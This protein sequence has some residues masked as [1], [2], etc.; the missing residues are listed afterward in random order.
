MLQHFLLDGIIWDR[1]RRYRYGCR[2]S[3]LADSWCGCSC[4]HPSKVGALLIHEPDHM[5]QGW[6]IPQLAV[7]VSRNAVDLANGRKHLRLFDGVDAKVSFEIEIQIQ[8]FF[9]I[10]SLLDHQRENAFL[11]G[12][13]IDNLGIRRSGSRFL[14]DHS[15]F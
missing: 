3:W 13:A 15:G 10:T 9:R 2:R 7:L 8:H 6:V 5:R 11:D 4:R 1:W 14:D 12:V